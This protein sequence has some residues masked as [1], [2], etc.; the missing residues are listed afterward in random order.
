MVA[1]NVAVPACPQLMLQL[2]PHTYTPYLAGSRKSICSELGSR[3]PWQW[4]GEYSRSCLAFVQTSLTSSEPRA[5]HEWLLNAAGRS[6]RHALFIS[7]G[8]VCLSCVYAPC[9]PFVW[10][11]LLLSEHPLNGHVWTDATETCR[12]YIL[13]QRTL[14]TFNLTLWLSVLNP[15][16]FLGGRM[17]CPL[18]SSEEQNQKHL[19]TEG[20]GAGACMGDC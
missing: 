8:V 2:P 14:E 17:C 1:G 15:E 12:S 9:L 3:V 13:Y 5:S 18:S 4:R 10:L 20:F 7:V 19:S 6:F 16:R 11:L